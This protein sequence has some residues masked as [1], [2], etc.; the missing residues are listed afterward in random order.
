MNTPFGLSVRLRRYPPQD[1]SDTVEDFYTP[2]LAVSFRVR[3]VLGVIYSIALGACVRT[4]AFAIDSA[5]PRTPR[6]RVFALYIWAVQ[7][8][9]FNLGVLGGVFCSADTVDSLSW[10]VW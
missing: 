8:L 6:T 10:G 4:C 9:Y 1:T 5:S 3:G 7:A 2:L